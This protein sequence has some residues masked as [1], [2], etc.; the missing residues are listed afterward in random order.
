V[1][2]IGEEEGEVFKDQNIYCNMGFNAILA[3]AENGWL[4][5]FGP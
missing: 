1:S 5:L 2:G 4:F 3:P